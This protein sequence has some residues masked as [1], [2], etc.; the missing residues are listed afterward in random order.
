MKYFMLVRGKDDTHNPHI[1][2]PY[3]VKGNM[4]IRNGD[5]RVAERVSTWEIRESGMTFFPDVMVE[6]VLLVK[7]RARKVI[8]LFA[9]K[10]KY[11][12]VILLGNGTGTAE[13]YYLPLLFPLDGK[14]EGD[15]RLRI[16]QC[17]A[18]EDSPILSVRTDEN[19]KILAGVELMEAWLRRK[20]TGIAVRNINIV[21]E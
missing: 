19:L 17:R 16:G 21:V 12:Q 5:Y 15:G 7:D 4:G 14:Q 9:P 3:G 8:Q 20:V 2:L 1:I 10:I 18:V 6:P 11:K 13:L